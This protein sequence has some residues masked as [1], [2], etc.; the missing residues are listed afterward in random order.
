MHGLWNGKGKTDS[1]E[2]IEQSRKAKTFLETVNGA[3]ILCGDLNLL[4]NTHALLFSNKACVISSKP[5]E[6]LQLEA[7]FTT[8]MISLLI[9]C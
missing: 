1:L 8:E 3:K 5:L 4:P 7:Y 2:R 9:M 6:S